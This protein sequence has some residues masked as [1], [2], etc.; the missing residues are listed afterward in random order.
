MTI[1]PATK[2]TTD[3]TKGARRR[4]ARPTLTPR[5]GLWVVAAVF[6]VAMA[7]SAVPTPLWSLYQARDG[8]SAFMVTVAFAAYAAGVIVS[9]LLAGRVSDWLG[10]RRVLIPALLIEALSAA[11]F[12]VFPALPGLIAA[13]IISGLGI[14]MITATSAAYITELSAR[15]QPNSPH[16]GADLIATAANMGGFALGPLIAGALAQWVHAPLRVPF[17]AF[18]ALL[19]LSALGLMLVPETVKPTTER[20]AYHPQRISVPITSRPQYFAA[21]GAA[22]AAF[23][24]LGLFTSLAPTFVA[25]TLGYRSHALAGLIAFVVFGTAAV[26]QATL[27]RLHTTTQLRSG[28][29]LIPSGLVL[30]TISVF[31][32][33]LPPFLVGGALAGAGAGVLFKAS[34]TSGSSFAES[35]NRSETLTGL[36]LAAYIGLVV[37]ILGLG[38]AMQFTSDR[39]GLLCFAIAVVAVIAAIARPLLR[40]D[41]QPSD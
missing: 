2:A 39:N 8:F 7:F 1:V 6:C 17:I 19:L 25:V 15:A 32:S 13:R 5:A 24:V 9:L 29:L 36:F 11:V 33:S 37:P 34:L 12:L 20:P 28:L 38:I 4:V 18:L 40:Q 16:R 27:S 22:F 26:A 3:P 31:L 41:T 14:G 10:R 23:S 30:L 35:E 21:A